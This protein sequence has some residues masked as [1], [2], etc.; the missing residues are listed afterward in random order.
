VSLIGQGFEGTRAR[1]GVSL[2]R[3]AAAQLA[4]FGRLLFFVPRIGRPPLLA[5]V[6]TLTCRYCAAMLLTAVGKLWTERGGW[7]ERGARIEGGI[8]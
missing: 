5:A 2:A 4:A 3:A 1:G 6:L 7:N 8:G